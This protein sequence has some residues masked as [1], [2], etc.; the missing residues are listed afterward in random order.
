MKRIAEFY[1]VSFDQFVEDYRKINGLEVISKDGIT[2]LMEAHKNIRLPER[3][4]SGSAGYDFFS[5]F[6]FSV[7]PGQTVTFPTGIRCRMK[8]GWV[9][10]LFTRSSLG[11]KYRFQLDNSVAV[12]DY[13][14]FFSENEGHIMAKFTNDGREGKVVHIEPGKAYMQGVFVKFGIT[15]N[16]N[17][18]QKRNGGIGSTDKTEG[19]K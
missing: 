19:N 8:E 11:L 17:V 16:D 3:A 5:P 18:T 6:E 12:I 4:T 13:D 14:F 1:K 15:V 9:L 7:E 2:A 10:F